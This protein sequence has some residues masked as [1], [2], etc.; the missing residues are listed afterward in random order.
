MLGREEIRL[1]RRLMLAEAGIVLDESKAYLVLSRLQKLAREHHLTVGALLRRLRQEKDSGLTRTVVEQMAI[2]ETYFFRDTWLF[3]GLR[4]QMIPDLMARR[5]ATTKAIYIWC[6]AAATGQEIYSVCM[7]LRD[8]FP[9]LAD[10]SLI[11]VASDFAESALMQASSGR[12]SL[13]EVNRGLPARLL[14]SYFHRSGLDWVVNDDIRRMVSFRTINLILPWPALPAFDI[15]LVRNVLM[16]FTPETRRS[17]L[18]R[19]RG[20]LADGGS[21]LLGGG[22]PPPGV[23]E[24][25]VPHPVCRGCYQAATGVKP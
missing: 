15:I 7:M 25:F 9:T 13:P 14:T 4:D 10:W 17:V 11:I 19:L 20:S 1:V 16:Y 8:C 18:A 23:D 22:E 5:Q 24:Q 21:L 6:A 2:K 12:Y 3:E